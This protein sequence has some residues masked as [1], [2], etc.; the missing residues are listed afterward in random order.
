MTFFE[1][2]YHRFVLYRSF[3]AW[4]SRSSWR[5]TLAGDELPDLVA[6]TDSMVFVYSSREVLRSWSVSGFQQSVLT[7]CNHVVS[8]VGNSILLAIVYEDSPPM[9]SFKMSEY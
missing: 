5:I 1:V 3:N 2:L 9:H 8:M 6:C 7:P 4:T